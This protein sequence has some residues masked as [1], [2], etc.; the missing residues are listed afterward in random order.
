MGLAGMGL[1]GWDN[2]S[3]THTS[4]RFSWDGFGRLGQPEFYTY[5]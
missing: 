4:N 1:V 2:L 5:L 3:S